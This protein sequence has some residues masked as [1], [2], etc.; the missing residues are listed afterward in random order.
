MCI[1]DRYQRRVRGW[2]PSRP[3]CSSSLNKTDSS[4]VTINVQQ[5]Q[6]GMPSS[7]ADNSATPLVVE[8]QGYGAASIERSQ[9]HANR[10]I[11]I[12][13]HTMEQ[14]RNDRQRLVKEVDKVNA[15]GSQH[16]EETSAHLSKICLLYTS[17][18]PR[19]S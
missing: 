1:R 15:I 14:L 3:L 5:P 17:P 7:W 16:D 10:A 11:E 13:T 18:S 2:S 9:H 19:D 4:S 12:N 8:P 6:E